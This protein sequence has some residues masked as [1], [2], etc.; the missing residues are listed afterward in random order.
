MEKLLEDVQI[1]LSVVVSD[2]FG[3]SG[4]AMPGALADGERR[5]RVLAQPARVDGIEADIAA[6]DSRIEEEI[7]PFDAAL[8]RPADIPGVQATA[9]RVFTPKV[10]ESAGKRPTPSSANA[11]GA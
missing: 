7:A 6:L 11:T 8:D 3:V 9:A 2:L 10:K 1:K 4:R 5:P